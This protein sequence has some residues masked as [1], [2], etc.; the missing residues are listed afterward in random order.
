MIVSLL[1]QESGM[2]ERY[3]EVERRIHLGEAG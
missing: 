2:A 1:T 3:A